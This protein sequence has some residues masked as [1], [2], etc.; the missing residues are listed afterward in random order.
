MA[1]ISQMQTMQLIQQMLVVSILSWLQ[2][3]M[4]V[5]QLQDFLIFLLM[6]R[7]QPA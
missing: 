4:A 1:A 5:L 6:L 3:A 7:L 2:T